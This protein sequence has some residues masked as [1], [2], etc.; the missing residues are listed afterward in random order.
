V[1]AKVIDMVKEQ[2]LALVEDLKKVMGG[3]SV[4]G[5][6]DMHK[7]ATK[8]IQKIR[9]GLEG[10]A[11]IKMTKKSTLMYALEGMGTDGLRQLEQMIPT[12][13]ALI[14]T[15]EDP[16]KFYVAVKNLRFRT[17]AKKGDKSNEDIWVFAGPTNLLAG[18]AIS[19]F[20]GVGLVAGVEAGKIAIKKDSLFVKAGEE[21]DGKKA[22]ILRKLNIE[23][24]EV[25]LNVVT[26]YDKGT[27]YSKDVLDMSLS[28]PLMIPDAFQKAINL[29]VVIEFPTKENIKH[30]LM[31]AVRSANAINGKAAM[32][33]Q[34]DEKA[35]GAVPEAAQTTGGVS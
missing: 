25:T 14:L 29:S 21:I 2:K 26:L 8:Q 31:K 3:Y 1:N 22:N 19:D 16:F 17:Y 34:A 15:K 28:F 24:M 11:V 33:A 27:I 20:Q 13:P 5:L 6:I 10:K 12:Q 23:P 9:K 32:G 7:A 18:P 4:I 30:L 35:A